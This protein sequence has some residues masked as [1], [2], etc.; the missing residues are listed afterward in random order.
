MN[1]DRII[2]QVFLNIALI[3]LCLH[4]HGQSTL[5][6]SAVDVQTK[7]SRIDTLRVNQLNKLAYDNFSYNVKDLLEYSQQA[8]SLAKKL[9][10]KR[11]QAEA[12]KNLALSSMLIHGDV[13]ALKYLN[14]S[15]ALFNSLKDTVGIATVTNYMGCYYA[16]VKD[17]KQALPFFLKSQKLLGDRKHILRLTILTNTGSCYEDLK[18]YE[19][20][21]EC[22]EE[23]EM[24]ADNIKDYDWITM[25]LVNS[26][27]LYY[28]KNDLEVALQ[29]SDKAFDIILTH[30]VSPREQQSLY[31]LKGDIAYKLKRYESSKRYYQISE[32][33]AAQMKSREYMAEIYFK[34]HLLDSISGD[35][36]GALKN[37][38]SYQ[39]ITDSLLNKNKNEI[40]ALHK[41][42][43]ALDERE[44]ENNRLI[45]AKKNDGKIIFYQR[46]ILF[47]ALLGFI[48]IGF[49]FVRLKKLNFKLKDLNQRFARQ[50]QELE[51]VN[52]IK[53]KIF[54]VIAH[55]LRNPFAQFISILDMFKARLLEADE[56]VTLL[57][58]LDKSVNNT[59]DMMDRLLIWSKSQLDGFK[60][61]KELFDVSTL[62]QDT[63]EKLQNLIDEK[64][65]QVRI[66][67]TQEVEAWAD[68]EMIRIVFRNLLSNAIKFTPLNGSINIEILKENES[69]N[70]AFR[71]T[72]MG[73]NEEQ[74][75]SLF[76]FNVKS[77]RGTANESGTGLGLKICY[78]LLLLNNGKIRVESV[79]AKGSS[80]FVI[81][82]LKA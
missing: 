23:A 56:I 53:N 13:S 12:Y 74:L 78:D 24:L 72:G 52:G 30:R 76:S 3:F 28:K 14:T 31:L 49:A 6:D 29:K 7:D 22:F 1:F 36:Q 18:E 26:A 65:L 34:F 81:L 51:E 55:D 67:K 21:K 37:F 5:M 66:I 46:I 45:E 11:G 80:F 82:P 10:Y 58:F 79:L 4:V 19:K 62:I 38:K 27:S 48:A 44:D 75:A 40:I 25:S 35:Y 69:V 15:L 16:T 68:L 47:L 71:D 32:R 41:V 54:S 64:Q 42:R 73:L 2:I 9:N 17:F 20:A 63:V 61:K 57:P 8:L 77:T 60:V 59:I 39:Q 70:I 33:F 50:N 43:F